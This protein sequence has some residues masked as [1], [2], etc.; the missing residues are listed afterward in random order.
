MTDIIIVGIST[1]PFISRT[2]F[3]AFIF[4]GVITSIGALWVYF[5]VP[6]TKGRTL[7]V[8]SALQM[9][10][11]ESIMLTGSQ[12]MDELFGE[13]GFAAADLATKARIEREVGLTALLG[14]EDRNAS[15]AGEKD[16][17]I[18]DGGSED[19]VEQSEE[20]K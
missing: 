17:K 10:S 1:S 8:R 19:Q 14:D 11:V 9:I 6:E 7:E 2:Q 18:A 20:V 3:G 12:E 15:I 13:V 16:G 4:F 5:F